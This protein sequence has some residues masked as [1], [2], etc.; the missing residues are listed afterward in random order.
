MCFIDELLN[1][2]RNKCFKVDLRRVEWTNDILIFF[3]EV[4]LLPSSR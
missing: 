1:P 3:R 4:V 2:H